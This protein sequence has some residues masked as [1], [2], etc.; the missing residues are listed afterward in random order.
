MSFIKESVVV[1]FGEGL[2]HIGLLLKDIWGLACR[3]L[4]KTMSE[5]VI[6]AKG[7]SLIFISEEGP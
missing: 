1:I 2:Y 3:S 7:M 5:S 4:L 6:S